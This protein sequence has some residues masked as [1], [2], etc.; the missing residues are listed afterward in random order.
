M[1]CRRTTAAVWPRSCRTC[2]SIPSHAAATCRNCTARGR[3]KRSSW[4]YWPSSVSPQQTA[5]LAM[6]ASRTVRVG[7]RSPYISR[8]PTMR[9]IRP[10]LK[11]G[12]A[13]A[14]L[15]SSLLTAPAAQ[16]VT[17]VQSCNYQYN[18]CLTVWQFPSPSATSISSTA[19]AGADRD[20]HPVTSLWLGRWRSSATSDTIPDRSPGVSQ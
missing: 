19:S 14:I 20:P 12:A 5:G 13:A 1:S 3:C 4:N 10:L 16:A 9:T 6:T 17:C 8:R 2:G 7:A 18:Q 15:A 11:L